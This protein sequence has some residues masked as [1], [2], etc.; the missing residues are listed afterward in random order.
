[1]LFSGAIERCGPVERLDIHGPCAWGGG[2]DE[3]Q[4][5]KHQA[6]LL[7]ASMKIVPIKEV[8]RMGT[9]TMMTVEQFAQMTR[10]L[11]PYIQLWKASR[12]AEMATA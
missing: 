12:V 9:K 11:A 5:D 8:Y 4:E 7:W 1:M 3:R 10:D 2:A 6:P